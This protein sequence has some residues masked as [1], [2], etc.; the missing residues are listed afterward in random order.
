VRSVARSVSRALRVADKARDRIEPPRDNGAGSVSGAD[1]RCASSREPAEVTVQSM[2][3]EQ[4][5]APLAAER[6]DQFEIAAGRLVD[7]HGGAGASR[8]GG[9]SG[10]RLPSCVR[11]T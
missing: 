4:R 5:S 1:S 3:I 11:S 10:G 7:R 2:A 9:D 8:N 6:S